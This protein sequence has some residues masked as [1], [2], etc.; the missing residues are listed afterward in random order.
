VLDS[1]FIKQPTL[2][3]ITPTITIISISIR[4]SRRRPLLPKLSTF[5]FE[6]FV[7]IPTWSFELFCHSVCLPSIPDHIKSF[8]M[9]LVSWESGLDA[10][11]T[12]ITR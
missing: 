2:T 4:Q 6:S 5:W 3:I 9:L 1:C 7:I 11:A 10:R 12:A 8:V